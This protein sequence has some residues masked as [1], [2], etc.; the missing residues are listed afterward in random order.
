[1]F[2]D[3]GSAE[4]GSAEVTV[5]D[6][7]SDIGKWTHHQIQATAPAGTIAAEAFALFVQPSDSTLGGAIFLDDLVFTNNPSVDAPVI[8]NVADFELRQNAPNP[9]G[10]ATNI[11]FV[12][13]RGQRV[14]L[15]I[16]D[17]AGRR[18]AQLVDGSMTAGSH[19]VMWDGKTVNG[20]N[21]ASGVYTYVLRTESGSA[22]KQMM[23]L[24]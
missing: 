3:I 24:K 22:S 2:R 14:E 18:V 21:A 9:F 10:P 13:S 1:M 15:N 7:S 8:A 19:R 23:L 6:A 11:D 5:G 17:V 4:I 20:R 16:Y 12:L